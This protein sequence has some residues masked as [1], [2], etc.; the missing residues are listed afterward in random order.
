M[1]IEN[2]NFTVDVM[3]FSKDTVWIIQVCFN[4]TLQY[5]LKKLLLCVVLW[6]HRRRI[7]AEEKAKVVAAGDKIY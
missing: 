5:Q 6:N 7:Y 4:N 3:Y 1:L 2:T